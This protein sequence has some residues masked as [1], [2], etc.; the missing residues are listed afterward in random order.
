MATPLSRKIF[1]GVMSG[2]SLE[3]CMW[4]LRSVAKT[5]L[6][7]F[8]GDVITMQW[9]R[10]CAQ[11]EG[12][13]ECNEN[14]IVSSVHYVH[15]G[16][17]KI[18]LLYR[19]LPHCPVEEGD[20]SPQITTFPEHQS[21]FLLRYVAGLTGRYGHECQSSGQHADG[22]TA[23][24]LIVQWAPPCRCPLWPAAISTGTLWRTPTDG[25]TTLSQFSARLQHHD[26]IRHA[27]SVESWFAV[28]RAFTTQSIFGFSNDF[29][30]LGSHKL[31]AFHAWA[32]VRCV[33]SISD[34]FS[35]P[36]T[37][38][39]CLCFFLVLLSTWLRRII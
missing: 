3:T 4:N 17:I 16:E 26:S 39:H 32:N 7:L 22:N 29:F 19:S 10:R 13:T 8:V 14:I 20:Q 24:I 9:S 12:Q 2:L 18:L 35:N 21:Q 33:K 5:V 15:L 36:E 38:L 30:P 34:T 25:R 28:C 23:W 27:Q 31:A 1:L 37:V 11:T 6:K